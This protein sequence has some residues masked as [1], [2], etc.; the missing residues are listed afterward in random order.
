MFDETYIFTHRMNTASIKNFPITD[1]LKLQK[2]HIPKT[3][4][5]IF[6]QIKF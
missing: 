2:N 4:Y 1:H 5:K 6:I 3:F